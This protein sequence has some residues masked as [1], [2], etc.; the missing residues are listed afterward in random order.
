M[1][2]VDQLLK[3]IVARRA[4]GLLLVGGERALLKYG[5]NLEPLVKNPIP[6]EQVL[7]LVKEVADETSAGRIDKGLEADFDYELDGVG[8]FRA[9]A[10]YSGSMLM[11]TFNPARVVEAESV[12]EEEEE[13]EAPSPP[14]DEGVPS[15][16]EPME[17]SPPAG[18]EFE[19]QKAVEDASPSEVIDRLFHLVVSRGASDLHLR[20]NHVPMI[21]VD[22]WMT[23]LREYPVFSREFTEKMLF[24]L[25]PPRNRKQFEAINDTDFA[26]D[27]S[28]VARFRANVFRD[29]SGVGA[30]FRQIPSVIRPP[31][32]LGIPKPVQQLCFLTKGLVLVTG[33]TGSGKSTTLASLVDVINQSRQ[34]HIVTIEDPIEFVHP[35]KQCLVT[36]R[37]VGEHT[38][39]FKNA[40]RAAL[41]MDPD[42][43]LVGEMRDLETIAIAIET[44]VT[45]HL[46]FGT[47]HTATAVQTVDRVID[48]FP[49]DRQQQIR[50]MLA[51][52]LK[53][54]IAQ[55]L[56]RKSAGGRIAAYEVLIGT[57][58]VSNLIREAKTYQLTSVMQTSQS[59]GMTVLNNVL[60]DFVKRGLVSA[61][62]AYMKSVERDHLLGLFEKNEIELEFV[63]GLRGK[64]S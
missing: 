15:G 13:E 57:Q 19:L 34:D 62:E 30:V 54:V 63:R 29:R 61:Q 55:T 46:V 26:L 47:L 60:F 40:L 58:G 7:Q 59:L 27:L 24:P 42:I 43:V 25:M 10:R 16:G 49:A 32:D 33:P 45:G 28:G 64:V 5:E 3:A 48:Q 17:A 20:V 37:E 23:P 41:R 51:D 52:C 39:S 21:R 14:A 8:R 35:H 9:E 50:V 12:E 2:K 6:V 18:S 53:G 44:A 22:G 4:H 1:A 38:E 11:V 56:L 36:Q 31:D